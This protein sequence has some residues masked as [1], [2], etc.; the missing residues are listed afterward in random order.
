MCVC[1]CE[2]E[3]G[4][5]GERPLLSKNQNAALKGRN[6]ALVIQ[7]PSVAINFANHHSYSA[8]PPGKVKAKSANPFE[9]KPGL[10]RNSKN[11]TSTRAL[12]ANNSFVKE[13]DRVSFL[14][15]DLQALGQP[16][17]KLLYQRRSQLRT[18]A[19]RENQEEAVTET[20]GTRAM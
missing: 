9:H 2:R 10:T 8:G 18:P 15:T 11:D 12:S 3:R 14:P 20:V 19:G 17:T 7:L 16:P 5:G 4:G 6:L 13:A 1:V